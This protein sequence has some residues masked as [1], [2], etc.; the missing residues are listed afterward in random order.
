MVHCGFSFI[1]GSPISNS[2]L[3]NTFIKISSPLTE[4]I[5]Y[6]ALFPNSLCTIISFIALIASIIAVVLTYKNLSEMRKQLNEQQKQYFEQN[7]GNLVFYIKKAQ[8]VLP[9]I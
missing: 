1:T 5:V 6:L 7:R 8:L 2:A 4:T 9:T 3:V